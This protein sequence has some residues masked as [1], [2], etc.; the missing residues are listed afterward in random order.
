MHKGIQ[1]LIADDHKLLLNSFAAVLNS[2]TYV[3]SVD[4]CSNLSELRNALDKQIPDVVFLDLNLPPN[5]G[6][7]ICAELRKQYKNLCIIILTSYTEHARVKAAE[8]NGANAYFIKS[9]EI[10]A[11]DQ[12]LRDWI[13]GK[14]PAFV[15]K[16]IDMVAEQAPEYKRNDFAA[17]SPLTP[18]EKEIAGLIVSGKEHA[19]ITQLLN[20]SYDTYKTHRS[21]ILQKLGLKNV[22]E[23][24]SYSY[25]NSH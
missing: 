4:T 21:N 9:V 14:A 15:T 25:K 23:L 11:V 13:G 6:L 1:V 5:N 17:A 7:D 19:E 24:V 16:G 8:Q 2:F 20:I 10:E 12:Y 22:A 18:R 3:Q